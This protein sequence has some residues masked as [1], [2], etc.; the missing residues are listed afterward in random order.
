MFSC[1]V[2]VHKVLFGTVG[3]SNVEMVSHSKT[4]KEKEKK[5]HVA[6]LERLPRDVEF[7]DGGGSCSLAQCLLHGIFDPSK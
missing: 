4:Q 2:T 1:S 6:C 3:I 7:S 5:I